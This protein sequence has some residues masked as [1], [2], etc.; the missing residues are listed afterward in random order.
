VLV[1][2]END[3]VV[4]RASTELLYARFG[5]GIASLRVIAGTNHNTISQSPQYLEMMQAAL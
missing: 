2:A 5:K 1:A 3:G 4:P